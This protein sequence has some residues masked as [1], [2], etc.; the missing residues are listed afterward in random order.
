MVLG[1]QL[2]LSQQRVSVP[3]QMKLFCLEFIYL[4]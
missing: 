2:T 1:N 4:L 3:P